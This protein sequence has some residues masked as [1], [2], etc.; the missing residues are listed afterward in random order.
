MS[1]TWGQEKN[2]ALAWSLFCNTYGTQWSSHTRPATCA[3]VWLLSAESRSQLEAVSLVA[4]ISSQL[5][6]CSGSQALCHLWGCLS[7][8]IPHQHTQGTLLSWF[9]VWLSPPL[10]L[11]LSPCRFTEQLACF[12]VLLQP[13]R[14]LL[15][16]HI[17][18]FLCS[19]VSN[20]SSLHPGASEGPPRLTPHHVLW[21]TWLA[22][23]TSS[24]LKS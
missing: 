8:F 3:R 19:K 10:V 7:F 14:N 1:L 15:K 9:R 13:G 18:I 20:D 23:L 6:E 4:G 12:P 17:V 24:M 11:L 5:A 21:H 16:C 22:H 2:E